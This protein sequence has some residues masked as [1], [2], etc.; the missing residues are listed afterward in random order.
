MF[1]FLKI[2]QT[3]LS[4][5]W[6]C[7]IRFICFYSPVS[8]SQLLKPTVEISVVGSAW[9]CKQS[10]VRRGPE[11][12]LVEQRAGSDAHFEFGIFK[13]ERRWMVKAPMQNNHFWDKAVF[14]LHTHICNPNNNHYQHQRLFWA[15]FINVSVGRFK[16][17]LHSFSLF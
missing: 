15:I 5:A 1:V 13:F 10:S 6:H 14:F 16:G 7:R 9:L 3:T 2:G 17:V 12:S 8:C 11:Q 4:P